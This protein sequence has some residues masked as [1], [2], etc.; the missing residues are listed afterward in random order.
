METRCEVFSKK[1][2]FGCVGLDPQYDIEE[3]KKRC[4]VYQE[5]TKEEEVEQMEFKEE[6][7]S[8]K[9]VKSV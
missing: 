3:I 4:E 2:C 9:Q 1:R 5:E 8:D 7:R 6:Y